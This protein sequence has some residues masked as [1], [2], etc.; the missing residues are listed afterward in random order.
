MQMTTTI[1]RQGLSTA[2]ERRVVRTARAFAAVALVISAGVAFGLTRAGIS[3]WVS[4]PLSLLVAYATHAGLTRK[5]R[6]RRAILAQPFPAE[7]EAI[8]QREVVFFRALDAEDQ[9]R[10]RRELQLFLAEKRIT[11]IKMELDRRY[12]ANAM[13][14]E[15]T[16]Q[17]MNLE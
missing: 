6:R 16:L 3:L 10:F 8:L 17:E 9:Q 5:V 11:G 13:M 15:E 2:W 14:Q 1:H 4:L 7:W 12:M